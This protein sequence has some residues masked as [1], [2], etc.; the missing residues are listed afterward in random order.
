MVMKK[1]TKVLKLLVVL[2]VIALDIIVVKV[3][4]SDKK[5]KTN[6]SVV[7]LYDRGLEAVKPEI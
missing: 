3:V 7:S 6:S 4:V 2:L 1:Q 5:V